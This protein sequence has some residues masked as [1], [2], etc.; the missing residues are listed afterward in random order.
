MVRS[1]I[2]DNKWWSNFIF[3]INLPE[4]P[5]FQ[6]INQSLINQMESSGFNSLEYFE[7]LHFYSLSLRFGFFELG[8]YLRKK[9]LEIAL[10]YSNFSKKNEIWKVKA[11]LSAL[12]ET[13]NFSDFDDLFLLFKTRLNKEKY[14]FTYLR[15]I[16]RNIKK[17]SALDLHT[18]TDKK[19]D[20]KF[21][22]FVE[23]KKIAIV[24]PSPSDKKDGY[25]IDNTDVVIRTNNKTHYSTDDEFKGSRCDIGYFNEGR[26]KH[27]SVNG[28]SQWPLD[29]SW[30]VGKK[31]NIPDLILKRLP[32]DGID[33]KYLNTRS[34]IRIDS[35]LFSGSLN[36][37]P[38]IIFDLLRHNPKKI[39]LYHFDM[40]LTKDR[41]TG[42]IPKSRDGSKSTRDLINYNLRSFAGHDPIT[43]FLFIK[44]LWEKGL[45]SGDD[46]FE[47]VIMMEP[48]DYMKNLQNNYRGS[49]DFK[50][51]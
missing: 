9:S 21:R 35:I 40:M 16:F 43:S 33:V 8:Y 19:Q 36:F 41:I 4:G 11:K 7:V 37:L 10:G 29:M 39:F 1:H 44:S 5:K 24:S 38:N 34:L 13:S 49:K 26:A 2:I 27:I 32:I 12:L 31:S 25:V 46:Y 45:I 6:K 22:K 51:D 14:F 3:L 50:I 23:K 48:K 18:S 30:I 42:Y 20:Q 15:E 47:R 17:Q 28:I